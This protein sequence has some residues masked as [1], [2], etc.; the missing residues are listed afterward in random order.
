MNFLQEKQAR[1]YLVFLVVLC[2]LMTACAA[3]GGWHLG[4]G[5]QGP[6]LNAQRVL[7]SGL[8]EQGVGPETIAAAMRASPTQEGADLMKRMGYTERTDP[9]VLPQIRE[10]AGRA[11]AILAGMGM[12]FSIVI[13]G[14]GALF[15]AGRERLY[16]RAADGMEAFAEGNFSGHLP[17][18][19]PGTLF[20]LFAT[21]E[22][23][24][25]ALRAKEEAERAQ[26]EF[27][28]DML[29]DISH[30]LKTPLAAMDLYMQILLGE[31]GDERAV[32]RFGEKAQQAA[33]RMERLIGLL[34]RMARLDAGSIAFGK[35]RCAVHE[36]VELA[37]RELTAR[38]RQEEKRLL[39]QGDER[40]TLLCDMEWTAE[41]VGNLIKN[42]LDHVRPGGTVWVSWKRSPAMTRI[43]VR[44]DGCGISQEDIH[45]IFKRFY[46]SPSSHD[47]QGAGLGLPL[48]RAIV[49]GQGG[50][51]SVQSAPGR[52]S[53]FTIAF[54]S[55][56]G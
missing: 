31:P 7:V 9:R 3:M 45:H 40:E 19:E 55:Q 36:L 23:L 5:A 56:A 25:L 33:A 37:V 42:A 49:E 24:A 10:Y 43:F 11:A 28:K 1:R 29:S 39:I 8:L 6:V 30:Q 38:A 2:T 41:A 46:R 26:K 51:L 44:D 48:A 18:G 20:R 53:I 17:A 14:G 12:A 13:T 27:L 35:K 54:A 50:T 22:Q 16:R 52:G 34:L 4:A 15:L 21:A 47:P 32:R